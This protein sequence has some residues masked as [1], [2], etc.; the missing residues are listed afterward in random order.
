LLLPG[1][2][3]SAARGAKALMPVGRPFLDHALHALAEAG[4][5]R[6]CVVAGP[7]HADLAARYR[8]PGAPRRLALSVA[9][10][11]EPRG[12][13]DALL[14]AEPA[15][16]GAPFLVVNGDN[17]YPAAAL[18]ALADLDGPGL[19][20][21]RAAALVAGG[22]D[23]ERL[24]RFALVQTGPDG[25]LAAIREKPGAAAVA[26]AGPDALVSMNSWR[27]D[28]AI[29]AACRA[30]APSPRGE[31]ELQDAVTLALAR[32]AR[33]RVIPWAGPVLDLTS[34]ADVPAVAAR[35]AGAPVNL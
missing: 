33:F 1:Q 21:F 35:L 26:A 19:V 22:L 11:P 15:A 34:R 25:R 23:P 29:F 12:T 6:V 9:V 5:R 31:L 28:A 18:A 16:G 20:A 27:F 30:V 13:A 8:G 24:G 10:Q 3:S 32:G 4:L 7:D 17:L 2:E 14:C